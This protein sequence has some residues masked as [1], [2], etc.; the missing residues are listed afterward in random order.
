MNAKK[1]FGTVVKT[2]AYKLAAELGLQEQSVL[3]WLRH[4]GYPNVRRADTIRSDVA[5]AAR[6]ALGTGRT[7]PRGRSRP[8]PETRS[9][10][11]TADARDGRDTQRIA[12]PTPQK[13]RTPKPGEGEGFRTSFAELLQ[14]HMPEERADGAGATPGAQ[15][16]PITSPPPSRGDAGDAARVRLARAERERGRL[17]DELNVERSRAQGFERQLVRQERELESAKQSLVA[18]E[19]FRTDYERL[20]LERTRLKHRLGEIEDERSTLEQTCTEL[21]NAL[22]D[23]TAAI[24]ETE[25]RIVDQSGVFDDLATAR[26]RETAWRTRALELERTASSGGDLSKLLRAKGI[27]DQEEHAH[28]VVALMSEERAVSTFMKAIRQIDVPAM[29]RLVDES[30]QATCV[31]PICRRLTRVQRKLVRHVPGAA[32]CRIC[33]GHVDQRWFAYLTHECQRAGVRRLLVIGGDPD[34]HSRLHALSEGAPIDL[35]IVSIDEEISEGRARGRVDGCDALVIWNENVVPHEVSQVY[36]AAADEINRLTVQIPGA[37][38]RVET[39]ARF[40]IN[41]LARQHILKAR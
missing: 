8:R 10:R 12:P 22:D 15:T 25:E 36:R 1:D 24:Q 11:F 14:N 39:L 17:N 2:K 21:K 35:R 9:N 13:P 26:K 34:H 41:R 7:S 30:I 29:E 28:V 40:T 5:Q 20:D 32:D 3:D 31:D 18:L 37:D 27:E 16:I 33:G 23:A 4:N 38:T 19:A 6:K